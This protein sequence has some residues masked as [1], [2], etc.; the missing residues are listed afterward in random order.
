MQATHLAQRQFRSPH[1]YTELNDLLSDLPKA[2]DSAL[3]GDVLAECATP[4]ETLIIGVTGSVA[5]GKS[6]FCSAIVD[7]LRSTM[8]VEIVSTD[9]FLLPNSELAD[10]GLLLR[11]GYPESYDANLMS[12]ALQRARWGAVRIPGYSHTTYD[13]A[14]ELD[15]TIDRPDILLVEGLGLSPTGKQRDPSAFL[16]LLIYID[17]A[18]RDLEDWFVRRF[19]GLWREAETNP[20]SFY[21]Q[22]RT[23]TETEADA[24]ARQVWAGINLPNLREHIAPARQHAD[25]LISKS[26]NHDMW[27]A[28]PAFRGNA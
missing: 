10:R 21:A 18:E 20:K 25:L 17:A 3:I 13:R 15:R 12:G 16:D 4:G 23:M 11:K 7:H 19:M 5:S 14:A 28:M 1:V 6:T 22:F 2:A 26:A 27:L 24:F 8:R 9:G